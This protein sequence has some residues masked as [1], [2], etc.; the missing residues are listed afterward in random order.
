MQIYKTLLHIWITLASIAAFLIGWVGLAHA[1]KPLQPQSAASTDTTTTTTLA[2][3]P[4]MPSLSQV[5]QGNNTAFSPFVASSQSVS[6]R[7]VFRSS[8][9]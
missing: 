1:P 8:G 4:P 7:H 3:L 5:Q 6:R 9:S 2:P